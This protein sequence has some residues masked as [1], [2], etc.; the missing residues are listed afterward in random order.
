MLKYTL[1][2]LASK[3]SLVQKFDTLKKFAT[4]SLVACCRVKQ[5]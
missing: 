5:L 2:G 4:V 1:N 3:E